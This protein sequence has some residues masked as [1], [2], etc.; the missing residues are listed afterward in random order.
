MTERSACLCA[1]TLT[2]S[3]L[4]FL[5]A[6]FF[7]CVLNMKYVS[8]GHV[9]NAFPLNSGTV[10]GGW[11]NL[12]NWGECWRKYFL[13]Y[14]LN[15]VLSLLYSFCFLSAMMW[16]IFITCSFYHDILPKCPYSKPFKTTSQN[17]PTISHSLLIYFGCKCAEITNIFSHF[18]QLYISVHFVAVTKYHKLGNS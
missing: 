7:C 6:I 13:E 8:Q 16:R 1:A 17:K 9:L 2:H 12:G 18:I 5:L 14:I 3:C 15:A 4:I 10:L 11:E